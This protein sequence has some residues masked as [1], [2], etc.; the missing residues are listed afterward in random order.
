MNR[1]LLCKVLLKEHTQDFVSYFAP[2]AHFVRLRDGQMQTRADSSQDQR[3]MRADI[4]AEVRR[5]GRPFLINFE[6][7]SSRDVRM[8][9]RL[10]GYSYEGTRL[11]HLAVLPCVIYTQPVGKVPQAPLRRSIPTGMAS[12]DERVIL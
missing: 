11:H 7:Q 3:E 2:D 5:G 9:E 12:T 1:D 6:W 4:L 10:L 8:D